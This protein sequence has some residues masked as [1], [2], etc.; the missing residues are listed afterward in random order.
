MVSNKQ[1]ILKIKEIFF[2]ETD[3]NNELTYEDLI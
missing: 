2:N 3:E 1:R